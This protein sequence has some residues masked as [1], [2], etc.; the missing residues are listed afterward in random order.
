MIDDPLDDVDPEQIKQLDDCQ[1][2][3]QIYKSNPS[4]DNLIKLKAAQRAYTAAG[5]VCEHLLP[6]NDC[7]CGRKECCT[8]LNSAGD[9]AQCPMCRRNWTWHINSRLHGRKD[10]PVNELCWQEMI[11]IS[12]EMLDDLKKRST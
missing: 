11:N 8:D 2:S 6:S 9:K 1:D 4:E 7:S 3:Y 5:H 12:Q 10:K